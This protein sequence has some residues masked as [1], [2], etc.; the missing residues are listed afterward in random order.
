MKPSRYNVFHDLGNG[1]T[2]AFNGASGALAEIEKEHLPR[3]QHLLK[4]PDQV[5]TDQDKEFLD[6]LV[7]GGYLVADAIDEVAV[8]QA[9]AG[10]HRHSTAALTMTIA[11]TLACNFG[12]NYCF[13]NQST[14]RMSE[15]TQKALLD[16]ADRRLNL[17][18]KMLIT[19]FGGEPTLC[20]PIIE[21]IQTGLLRLAEEHQVDPQPAS[22][23]SNGYLLDG[24]MAR[25]LKNIGIVEA[26]ITLDGPPRVHDSRRRLRSGKGTFD[27][28]IDNLEET[29][30]ILSVGIR[31]NV[32][33]EN[34]EDA[35]EVVEILQE[36]KILPKVKVYFAQVQSTG[37][38]C[39]DIRDRCFGPEEFSRSQVQLYKN[40]MDK[41]IYHVEY[42]QVSGGV[43]C[44]AVS[45]N[46]FVISPTG[47]L[48]KCWEEISLDPAKSVGD[49]FSSE[50]TDI[51]RTSIDRFHAW[52][53][54][55][56]S[57]CR[58]CN[59]LPICM[60]GCPI[61]GMNTG[62]VNKGVCSPWK[63]NLREMLELRYRCEA[64]REAEA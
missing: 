9:Q 27:R 10:A 37:G 18:S 25:F 7:S 29:S 14:V 53:P 2:L 23:I 50:L 60:G 13:E 61:H 40:L 24:D 6:G 22:I 21:R 58:E 34:T 28:I 64:A 12:C 62:C 31:I 15:E 16:F 46:S 38:A 1:V 42:P 56:F 26:Q 49:V 3:I 47:Q 51:Q 45:N 43:I 30:D 41:G 55:N 11:P 33:R 20:T 5:E 48:F 57:E 17:S 35:Y 39:A 52:N 59:I 54:F 44:G 36:R 4:H 19:W 8:F 63:Y 32:D